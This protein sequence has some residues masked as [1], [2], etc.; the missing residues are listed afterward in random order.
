[1]DEADAIAGYDEPLHNSRFKFVIAHEL[2]HG[3]HDSAGAAPLFNLTSTNDDDSGDCGCGF[4]DN[5]VDRSHCLQSEEPIGGAAAEGFAHYFAARVW[6][7]DDQNACTFVYYKNFNANG[8]LLRPPVVRSCVQQVKWLENKCG[9]TSNYGVEW[10]WMNA[11]KLLL[12][13]DRQAARSRRLRRSAGTR[14]GSLVLLQLGHDHAS[15]RPPHSQCLGIARHARKRM[16]MD[17]ERAHGLRIRKWPAGGSGRPAWE[18]PD[19][20]RE[21]GP[22]GRLRAPRQRDQQGPA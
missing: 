16:G 20:H 1:M 9:G 17:V 15:T 3:V 8:M 13:D 21:G 6:N 5:P 10:D 12:G 2:G 19:A 4:V 7:D 11:H 22:R 18:Q 14:T